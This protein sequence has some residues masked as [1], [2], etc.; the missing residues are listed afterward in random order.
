MRPF[1]SAVG[2]QMFLHR[3]VHRIE[4]LNDS[5]L[6]L[7]HSTKIGPQIFKI[8]AHDGRFSRDSQI[9]LVFSRINALYHYLLALGQTFKCRD[10]S[11]L[12]RDPDYAEACL[13]QEKDNQADDGWGRHDEVLNFLAH[14]FSIGISGNLVS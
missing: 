3:I 7:L 1:L 9:K 5:Q 4:R 8:G 11:L 10:A 6:L 12:P 14:D 2:A 13:R